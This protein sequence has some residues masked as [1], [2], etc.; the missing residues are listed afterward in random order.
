MTT[1]LSEMY[2]TRE[3][4]KKLEAAGYRVIYEPAPL[5]V[6][7]TLYPPATNRSTTAR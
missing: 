1:E 7:D 5:S 6:P 2:R 3:W 4:Q